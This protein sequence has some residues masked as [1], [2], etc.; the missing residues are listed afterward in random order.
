MLKE[1]N[2]TKL[3]D[4]F[5]RNKWCVRTKSDALVATVK[6]LMENSEN[7]DEICSKE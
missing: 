5:N 3:D 6:N 2:K 7:W 1:K 4:I